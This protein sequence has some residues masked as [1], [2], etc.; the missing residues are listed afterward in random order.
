MSKI[1]TILSQLD[2]ISKNPR[3]AMEDFKAK[4]GKGAV[5]ILPIYAPEEIVYATGYLPIGIWGATKKQILKATTNLPAFACSIMQSIM[6]LEL[7][8]TYDDLAAV[9]ISSPCDTLKCF[10]QK[11]KGKSPVIQ[12]AHSQN[13]DMEASNVYMVGEYKCI[14]EKL[15]NILGVT[16]TDDA[17]NAAIDVYNENRAVM[18]L[19]SDVAAMY[20]QVITPVKR[21]AVIKAR[22][23]M[24]KAEHTKMVRELICEL[25]K[26]PVVPFKGKKVVLTGIQ[27]EPDELLNIFEEFGIAVVADDLAQES[28]QFRTDV[29]A[30]NDPLYRLAK[31]WQ[32]VTACA[33][34]IDRDKP[35][36]KFIVDLVK[37][38]GADAVIVCMMKFCDPEE[39]DYPILLED[40]EKANVKN[41][42]IEIDQQ[43]ES[44]EQIRTRVQS[45][46]E[47]M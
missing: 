36:G 7:N 5:G 8:G 41:L 19:F 37:E 11:W 40:F 30:G 17:I 27:A 29:P 28:R 33:L 6:E 31:Q 3:K 20:P 21:H 4:T 24:D 18:R 44:L 9:I 15:E 34:A 2:A 43:S 46:V 35:R 42:K 10:G 38:H 26:Q 23:F 13:R 1:D 14:K 12:F 25:M 47:M 39:Y 45:F 32:N 22:Q 16:I